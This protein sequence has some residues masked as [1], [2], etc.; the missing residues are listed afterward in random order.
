[1]RW[2]GRIV[3]DGVGPWQVSIIAWRDL[4]A[5]WRAEVGKKL[6]AGQNLSVE[7]IEGRDL[8]RS[9]MEAN[10]QAPDDLADV[11]ARLSA[12]STDEEM[13]D[14]LLDDA[15]LKTLAKAGPRSN[16]TV[17]PKILDV[18]VDRALAGFSAWYELMPRSQTNDPAR[19]GT[20][21]DVIARLS[22]VRDL[23]FDVL[24]LPPIH[25][26]GKTN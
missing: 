16:L 6:A 19:H 15:T 21:G 10:V 14:L 26:I 9:A 20:F 13:L 18:W 7:I 1:D 17:Y 11:A 3:F 25:P 22:Y 12:C 4:F 2:S 23:G 24:Y 5:T 8:I